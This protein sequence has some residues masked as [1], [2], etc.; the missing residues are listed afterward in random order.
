[1]IER[2]YKCN[3][4]RRKLNPETAACSYPDGWAL[5]WTGP[6]RAEPTPGSSLEPCRPW[7]ESPVH[8]CQVCVDAVY[9][10]RQAAA[11]AGE[12]QPQAKQP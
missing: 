1:M 10:F 3:L 8:L 7:H 12:I 5:T 6:G 9:R 11:K 4:C 2:T